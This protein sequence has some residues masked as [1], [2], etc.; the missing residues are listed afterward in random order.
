METGG[1][2]PEDGGGRIKIGDWRRENEDRR[3]EKGDW[4]LETGK[5]EK[6]GDGRINNG[7]KGWEV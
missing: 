6:T 4:R 3:L 1:W 2:R 7:W 5:T